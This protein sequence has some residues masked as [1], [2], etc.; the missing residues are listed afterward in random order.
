MFPERKKK[1]KNKSTASKR[2]QYSSSIYFTTSTAWDDTLKQ[3]KH[4]SGRDCG[5]IRGPLY[6]EKVSASKLTPIQGKLVTLN[7][8][9][10]F[11]H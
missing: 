3:C 4:H 1:N 9:Y 6:L 2:H 7:Q 8:T 5:F 10:L 11:S